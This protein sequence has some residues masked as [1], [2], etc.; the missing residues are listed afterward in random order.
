MKEACISLFCGFL[1]CNANTAWGKTVQSFLKTV[2]KM[3]IH[4]VVH[5]S[6]VAM[7]SRLRNENVVEL[8]GYC[9]DGPQQRVLAYEYATMGS[10]HD[11]L[12]GDALS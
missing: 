2:R 3:L 12:H 11:I 8:V 9:L 6:Q 4:L 5:T 7:V 10:L 1:F